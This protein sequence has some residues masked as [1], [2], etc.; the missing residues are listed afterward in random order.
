VNSAPSKFLTL[1]FVALFA[2]CPLLFFPTPYDLTRNPY[3]TQIVLLN[4]L[5]CLVWLIWIVQAW[6]AGEWVW[7]RSTLDPLLGLLL[8][9]CLASWINSGLQHRN[10]ALSIYS[11]GS[12]AYIF[13]IVN[14]V[15]AYAAA[16]R[17]QNRDRF[18]MLLWISYAVAVFASLY[19]IAQF[20]GNEWFWPQALNPYGNR[21]VS[22]FGNP[23]FMSS[24]LVLIL[25]V[26]I[27]DYVFKVTAL[28]RAF[29]LAIVLSCAGALIATMTRSS[30]AGAGIAV[31]I[32]AAGSMLAPEVRNQIKKPVLLLAVALGLLIIGLPQ[33][34]AGRYS[35]SVLSRLEE[36]RQVA[37]GTYGAI[38][39]RLL[40]WLS[41]WHMV[42]DHPV[43]G[44]GWGCFELFYPFYQGPQLILSFF[45]S[46]RTHAN[47]AH[48][49][50][51]E[52]WSQVG[53]LGL[54]VM[55]LLWIT[56]YRR[57]KSIAARLPQPWKAVQWGL[58]GGVAG[59]LIDNLLNVSV[60]FAVPAF[61]FW[62]W[63][64]TAMR[65]DPS[66]VEVRAYSLQPVWRRG[67]MGAAALMLICFIGRSTLM[68]AGE[69]NF[70]EGFKIS[71]GGVQLDLARQYLEKAYRYHHLEVNNNYELANVFAR[72]KQWD[73]ALVMYQ[74]ALDAN[75]GYDEIW[76]NRGTIFMQN[77]RDEDAIRHYRMALGINPMSR[78]AYNALAGIYFKNP[79][80]YGPAAEAMYRKGLSLFPQ[81]KDLWNNLGYLYVQL[82]RWTEAREAYAKALSLDPN[83]EL[84][85]KNL[86]AVDYTLQHPSSV[87]K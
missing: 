7:V 54:G 37:G 85:R 67:I 8:I 20:Y 76:F 17:Y 35:S 46:Y 31:L 41:A 68:W 77:G 36:V 87:H 28:P 82:H 13:L 44:K 70:F 63:V 53:T 29:L 24:Y 75:M 56:F 3:Y 81:D 49:E 80:V 52:Y 51:L 22:T 32:M 83:F 33:N 21:P 10:L 59:M 9:V 71:K 15:L 16:V 38:T 1:C 23:N 64:G 58:V 55:I 14:T 42:Q 26:A 60:H 6:K 45:Q 12:R 4:I 27:A 30:W 19:G 50:I 11:E 48:D 62:W 73:N 66:A 34:T 79:A 84:A 47:N 78:E 74:R 5:I 65:L 61:V 86:A 40:I 18:K 72:M 69:I 2:V 57:A 43:L 39:Q 25:P